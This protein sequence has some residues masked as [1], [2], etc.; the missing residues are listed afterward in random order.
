[1]DKMFHLTQRQLEDL[2][3][4]YTINLNEDDDDLYRIQDGLKDYIRNWLKENGYEK[5]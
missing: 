1:M 3:E 4:K 2:L 5:K